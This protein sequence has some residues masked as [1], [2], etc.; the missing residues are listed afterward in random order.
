MWACIQ[1]RGDL[2]HNRWT[3]S[4]E[5]VAGVGNQQDTSDVLLKVRLR[6][7]LAPQL[8]DYLPALIRRRC[9]ESTQH[10][11]C[12]RRCGQSRGSWR[13]LRIQRRHH[14][15]VT[16]RGIDDRTQIGICGRDASFRGQQCQ[17]AN[18]GR[19]S[20]QRQRAQFVETFQPAHRPTRDGDN[21]RVANL[22]RRRPRIRPRLPLVPRP[23]GWPVRNGLAGPG[24]DSRQSSSDTVLDGAPDR[25]RTCGLLL[26]RQTLYP[27]SYGGAREKC[28]A[29]G[30]RQTNA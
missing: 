17:S 11:L 16:A 7:W 23:A 27:L 19:Q 30:P 21:I 10:G 2:A 15:R 20:G 8:V 5:V 18:C 25:I 13:R 28:C 29:N 14:L 24:A 22:N 6:F 26:R 3:R 1:W 12:R 4:S 9:E